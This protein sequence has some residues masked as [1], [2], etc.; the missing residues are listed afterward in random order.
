MT[1]SSGIGQPGTETTIVP[2]SYLEALTAGDPD[3]TAGSLAEDTTW[4][5]HGTLRIPADTA[6]DPVGAL[7]A[8]AF[9]YVSIVS[10]T[11]SSRVPSSPIPT[12]ALR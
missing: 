11:G 9:D 5:I 1:A 8:M 2:R 4:S 3:A 7:P 6:W 12:L 10:S